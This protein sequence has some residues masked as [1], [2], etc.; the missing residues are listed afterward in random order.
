MAFCAGELLGAGRE[1][2]LEHGRQRRRDGGD[3]QGDRG[4]EQA[5]RPTGLS[6]GPSANM[7]I[8]VP[9][10]A[11]PI[12]SV[13]VFSCFVSGVC[14][15]AV[16][17][18]MPAILPTWASAP[19]R[20]HDHHAA[21]VRDR[22]VH[23]R[24]VRLV[25]GPELGVGERVRRPWTPACSR[26]VSA[27][28]SMSSEFAWM[29]RP[30]A[31]T[32]SPARDQHDVADD[33]LL[34]RDR[35]LDPVAAHARGLLRQRLQGVHRALGLALLAQADD[36]VDHRQ[37][38]QHGARAP[39]ADGERHDGGD[40]QDDLHVGARTGRGSAASPASPFSAGSALGPSFCSSSA[41]FAA[42]R[43]LA[44]IDAELRGDVVGRERVPALGRRRAGAAGCVC[45]DR[46]FVAA[47]SG[48]GRPSRLAQRLR[49]R[50]LAFRAFFVA[51][52]AAALRRLLRRLVRLRAAA[53]AANG[54]GAAPLGA[55]ASSSTLVSSSALRASAVTFGNRGSISISA[56]AM[57][58]AAQRRANHL[59]SAGIT[60]QGA[61]S[62][63]V[64]ES[65][66][67]NAFW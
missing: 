8:I 18:S 33:D 38:E 3:R 49:C 36:G 45:H 37:Q 62:V 48:V 22:R 60:Y 47:V 28:S 46:P 32:L 19:R 59:W 34:G 42:D 9:S 7:T 11:A 57:T 43:P 64:A 20:G 2:H 63:L 15:L 54:S 12:H 26:P 51:F 41:A 14:S 39:L 61:H 1:D 13:I 52:L 66:S 31:A 17:A 56:L 58:A 65:I 53:S 55:S 40:E 30:S 23:E 25:A 16:A 6:R 21:A 24:H 44:G 67:E 10:A 35:R 29:I 27:D 50:F 5:C 4:D